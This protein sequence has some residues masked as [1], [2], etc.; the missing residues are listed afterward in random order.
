MGFLI[1]KFASWGIA[2]RFRKPLSYLTAAM[3]LFALLCL[4]KAIYDH[5]VIS[6]HE[7]KREVKAS[8][9]REAA[10]EEAARDTLINQ[11]NEKDLH[12]AIDTATRDLPPGDGR[13]SPAAHALACERL[14]K[15]GR[16]PPACRPE[17]GDG[18]K[19][20]AD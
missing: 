3:T 15:I 14:R 19:A 8:G 16:V 1:A 10:A 7:A 13:I 17:G 2:E 12:D 5:R 20:G 6:D 18:G 9:A 4:L 11:R